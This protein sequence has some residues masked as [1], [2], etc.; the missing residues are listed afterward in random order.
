MMKFL[1][2]ALISFIFISQPLMAYN[3]GYS[4][5]YEPYSAGDGV[6]PYPLITFTAKSD[7]HN[8]YDLFQ[9]KGQFEIKLDRSK[10]NPL[11][12]ISRSGKELASFDLPATIYSPYLNEAYRC[13]LNGD[14]IS[15][16]ICIFGGTGC[17]LASEYCYVIFVFSRSGD[18]SIQTLYTMGF[19][20]EDLVDLSGNGKCTIIHTWF[21]YGEKGTDGE[22]HNYWVYNF[23]DVSQT[24]LILSERSWK[25]IMYTDKPNHTDTVQLTDNQKSRCWLRSSMRL[26]IQ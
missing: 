16:Y 3:G 24:D 17:G 4:P 22:S 19:G 15:D 18:Y 6:K 10:E 25:W 2:L 23:F 26:F 8:E 12:K 13:D 1:L 11:L 5:G 14:G 9:S 21:V 20:P 7:G